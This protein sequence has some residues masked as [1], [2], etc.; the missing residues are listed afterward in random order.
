MNNS[1]LVNH[2]VF[3]FLTVQ[4]LQCIGMVLINKVEIPVQELGGQRGDGTYFQRELIFSR[5]WYY[6]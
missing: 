1:I 3:T 6:V 4:F 5:I 2:Q